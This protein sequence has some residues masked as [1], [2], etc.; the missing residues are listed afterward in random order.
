MNETL[1][2]IK[3]ALSE[4]QKAVDAIEFNLLEGASIDPPAPRPIIPY[5]KIVDLYHEKLPM[6]PR[7][8]KLSA[9]RSGQIRARWNDGLD[10]L[11]E[12]EAFFKKVAA[13]PFLTGRVQSHDGRPPFRAD[14]VWLTKE[15]NFLKVLEGK[16]HAKVKRA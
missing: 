9:A 14:L 8:V 11:E 16:Y 12:W 3:A 2:H 7:C 15:A 4:L 13:S 6:L 5:G 1:K 10:C